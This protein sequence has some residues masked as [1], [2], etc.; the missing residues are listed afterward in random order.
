MKIFFQILGSIFVFGAML[1]FMLLTFG[2]MFLDSEKKR[3]NKQ[4]PKEK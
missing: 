1:V 4:E 2:P 3:Q